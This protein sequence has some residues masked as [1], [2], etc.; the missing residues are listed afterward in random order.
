[1]SRLG[2]VADEVV[3]LG[4]PQEL[5]VDDHMLVQVESRVLERDLDELAHRVL[6]AGRD[7]VVV[8]LVGLEHQ[9]HRLDV[10][11]GVAPVALRVEV[12]QPQLVGEAQ[13]DARDAVR[14][15][16]RHELEATARPLVVEEDPGDREEAVRLA[17]VDGDEVAVDLRH[18]V[19]RARVERR[20]LRLRNL[21]HLPEHL[22]RGGLVEADRRVDTAHG[23][24]HA[25]DADRC[26]LRGQDRLLPGGR[27]EALRGEV[28]DLGRLGLLDRADE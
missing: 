9:P 18:A 28:V 2:G 21:A 1:M 25:R 20:R 7:H 23:L 22:R 11:A 24:E 6:L 26:E 16:A 12:A 13:L 17:V 27:D 3:D 14:D 4:R 8:G 19:G 15:L 10:V 5:G